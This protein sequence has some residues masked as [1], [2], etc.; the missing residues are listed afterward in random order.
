MFSQVILG[1]VASQIINFLI[2]NIIMIFSEYN[3]CTPKELTD[4]IVYT[5]DDFLKQQPLTNEFFC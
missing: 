2:M 1:S 4:V 3:L 5:Y